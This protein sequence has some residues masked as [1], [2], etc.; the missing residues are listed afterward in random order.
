MEFW[1]DKDKIIDKLRA[2]KVQKLIEMIN[3]MEIKGKL[4]L[5]VCI[6]SSTYAKLKYNKAHIYSMFNR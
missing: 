1:Q 6:S 4:R 3:N 5:G 2:E